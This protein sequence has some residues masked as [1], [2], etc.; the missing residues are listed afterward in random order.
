MRV[1]TADRI[2]R[3]E[4]LL[5]D[6]VVATAV[7]FLIAAVGSLL[8]LWFGIRRGLAPLETIR[9]RLAE[10]A[11]A[12]L[13][14]LPETRLP[15]ELTPLVSTIN[16]LLQRVQRAIERERSFTGNAAHELRTP[17]TAIKT[18]LQIARLAGGD[19][20][21]RALGHV[22]EGV[23]RLQHTLDQLLTLARVEGPFSFNGAENADAGTIAGLAIR[24]IAMEH[25]DRIAVDGADLA[26]KPAIPTLLAVTALRNLLDNALRYS[27]PGTPVVLD[28]SQCAG[29]LSF[30]IKDDGTGMTAGECEQAVQRFWRKGSAQGSGLGL[31][32]VDAVVKRYGG[33]L[34]LIP[35]EPTGMTV[36][37]RLPL[38]ESA[39][40]LK[41]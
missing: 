40:P 19:D 39:V 35:R 27:A 22:E 20:A 7:P 38:A 16:L 25:R 21:A 15:A 5:R 9:G 1:T 37:I 6:I 13:Q 31:S 23:L 41:T 32:I 12:M 34:R 10:Q 24:E 14:P 29:Q 4:A 18:H 36:E 17:L 8:A 30:R 11:P 33:E 26:A 28:I 2:D 3:R